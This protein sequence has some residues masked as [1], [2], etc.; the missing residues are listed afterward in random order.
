MVMVNERS[1][2]FQVYC[3]VRLH[4]VSFQ[5]CCASQEKTGC[6]RLCTFQFKHRRAFEG[7]FREK[8][9]SVLA[10]NLRIGEKDGV[11]TKRSRGSLLPVGRNGTTAN[12]SS[13]NHEPYKDGDPQNGWKGKE[14]GQV[15]TFLGGIRMPETWTD[16]GKDGTIRCDAGQG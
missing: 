3:I 11:K 12:L 16:F 5:C 6:W 9:L 2:Q 1:F 13:M 8:G 10:P 15:R 14:G 4:A 7:S